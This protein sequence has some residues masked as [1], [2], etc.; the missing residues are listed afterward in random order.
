MNNYWKRMTKSE[1]SNE[2]K[3]R[4]AK[5]R[6]RKKNFASENLEQTTDLLKSEEKA[7]LF[8]QEDLEIKALASLTGKSTEYMKGY[9]DGYSAAYK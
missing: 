7:I 5:G 9:I 6:R 2:M 8:T 1:R 4:Q 3:K